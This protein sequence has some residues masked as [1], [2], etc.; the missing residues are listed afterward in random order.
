LHVPFPKKK[1][2]GHTVSL[3]YNDNMW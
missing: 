3:H 1:K 2:N